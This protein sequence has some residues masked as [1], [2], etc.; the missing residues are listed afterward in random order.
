MVGCTDYELNSALIESMKLGDAS[1]LEL[2]QKRQRA[3]FVH[4]E[5]HR[6]AG[7]LLG[8]VIDDRAYWNELSEHAADAIRFAYVDDEPS[9]EFVQWCAYRGIDPNEYRWMTIDAL[10]IAAA[11]RRARPLLLKALESADPMV[12]LCAFSAIIEQRDESLL[13]AIE[14]MLERF[15]ED[16]SFASG[17]RAVPVRRRRS[18]GDEVPLRGRQEE[19]RHQRRELESASQ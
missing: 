18:R 7:A 1:A 8:R 12:V 6:L 4:A 5:R 19:Y 13:P 15:P 11:D 14:R 16:A 17:A 3:T 9:Q 10:G 2:L